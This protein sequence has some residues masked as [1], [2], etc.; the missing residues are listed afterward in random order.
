MADQKRAT[1]KKQISQVEKK[2]PV[3][4]TENL[5]NEAGIKKLKKLG[6]NFDG[7]QSLDKAQGQADT[8]NSDIMNVNEI[9]RL[10]EQVNDEYDVQGLNQA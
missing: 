8:R 3:F 10:I 7:N 4:G 5:M 9:Q 6:Y 2:F 1:H